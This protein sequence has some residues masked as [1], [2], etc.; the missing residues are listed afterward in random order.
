MAPKLP[1]ILCINFYNAFQ[2][3]TN[4]SEISCFKN[5]EELRMY[6]CDVS[7]ED[8][9]TMPAMEIEKLEL[10][11]CQNLTAKCLQSITRFVYLNNFTFIDIFRSISE[12][13][14]V[15][16]YQLKHLERLNLSETDISDLLFINA[17][18]NYRSLRHLA[19]GSTKIS[20]VL[21]ILHVLTRSICEM[22]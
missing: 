4:W 16:L 22:R 3:V 17:W 18:D 2:E 19:L 13:S 10:K 5:I 12:S 9:M 14:F 11:L 7:D 15:C 20:D 8:L 6:N 1:C 21:Q